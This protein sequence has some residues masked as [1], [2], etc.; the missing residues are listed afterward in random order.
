MRLLFV[1]WIKHDIFRFPFILTI[2]YSMQY[3][4]CNVNCT[5]SLIGSVSMWLV[6]QQVCH[7]FRDPCVCKVSHSLAISF[8]PFYLF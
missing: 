2:L 3:D 7:N 8:G 4:S 1:Y 5:S 6:E